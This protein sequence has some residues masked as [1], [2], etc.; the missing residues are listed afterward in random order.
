MW[1]RDS[2]VSD[3]TWQLTEALLVFFFP[4]ELFKNYLYRAL[5]EG[6]SNPEILIL[7]ERIENVPQGKYQESLSFNINMLSMD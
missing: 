4:N 6:E 3:Q 5:L 7:T 1:H 2:V